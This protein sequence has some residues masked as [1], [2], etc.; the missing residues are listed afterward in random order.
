MTS[1]H[2][3]LTLSALAALLM[4]TGCMV[5]PKYQKAPARVTPTFKEPLPGGWKQAEPSDGKIESK[6]WEMYHDPQLDAPEEA[7]RYFQ[8]ERA[9]PSRPDTAK[10]ARRC[11]SHGPPCSPP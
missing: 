4:T 10:P 7:G 8:P 1:T 5:G 2:R 6:W 11:E 9:R 3:A